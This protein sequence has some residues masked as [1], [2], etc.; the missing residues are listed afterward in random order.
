MNLVAIEKKVISKLRIES[1]EEI[2]LLKSKWE[3]FELRLNRLEII[4]K[5]FSYSTLRHEVE[6][7]EMFDEWSKTEEFQQND[8]LNSFLCHKI[9]Y[10]LILRDVNVNWRRI[11]FKHGNERINLIVGFFSFIAD[12]SKTLVVPFPSYIYSGGLMELIDNIASELKNWRQLKEG[13][14]VLVEFLFSLRKICELFFSHEAT[15]QVPSERIDRIISN[16]LRENLKEEELN[17]T[18]DQMDQVSFQLLKI[19]SIIPLRCE[20]YESMEWIY[21]NVKSMKCKKEFIC[22]LLKLL[23]YCNEIQNQARL[24]NGIIELIGE[25][26]STHSCLM[27]LFN[28]EDDILISVMKHS[29]RVFCKQKEEGSELG[30]ILNPVTI[31]SSFLE[32]IGHDCSLLLDF[33]LNDETCFLECVLEYLNY[34]ISHKDFPLD[35]D[36]ETMMEFKE[37]IIQLDSKGLF[38]FNVKPLIYKLSKL[39]KKGISL[40]KTRKNGR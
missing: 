14:Q 27:E 24:E 10:T 23:G 15:F 21:N 12:Q 38:P 37:R 26:N 34:F 7:E 8:P 11:L 13:F 22:I 1:E 5:Y 32:L 9:M 35:E 29:L 40:K 17:Q 19:Y 2:F 25:C 6:Y 20:F 36:L 4:D 28:E 33:L 31:F 18:D 30:D 3:A 16:I 39:D